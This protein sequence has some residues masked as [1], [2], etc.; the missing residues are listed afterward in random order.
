MFEHWNS[1]PGNGHVPKATRAPGVFGHSSQAQGGI[2]GVSWAGRGAG[3]GDP[4]GSLPTQ[5][6]P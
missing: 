4:C 2:V 6:T 5:D 1:S 3:L